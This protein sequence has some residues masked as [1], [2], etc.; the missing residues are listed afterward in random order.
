MKY[1]IFKEWLRPY[2]QTFREF[3]LESERNYKPIDT[4]LQDPCFKPLQLF[5]TPAEYWEGITLRDGSTLYGAT[6]LETVIFVEELA[7][8]DPSMYLSLP[9]PNLSGP[10]IENLGTKEQR[11]AY[12]GYF[13][14]HVAWSAFSLTEPGAG[15][16][17]TNLAMTAERQEDGSYLLNGTKRYIANAEFSEWFIVF[18]RSKKKDT[19]AA[20]KASP[21]A[22]ECFVFHANQDTPGLRLSHDRTLGQRA[23]RLG[24]V[25]LNNFRLGT[26]NVL[27]YDKKPLL[28]GLRGALGTFYHMRPATAAIAIGTSRA[29]IEYVEGLRGLSANEEIRL[30]RLKWELERGRLLTHWAAQE[31]DNGVFNSKYS[32]MAKHYMNQLVLKTTRECLQMVGVDGMTEH[33]HLEKWMRDAHMIEFMEGSTNIHKKEVATQLLVSGVKG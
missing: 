5:K 17:A 1:H 7:W 4:C 8:G 18:V 6:A 9:G 33:P 15:S 24:I 23:A 26:E 16:D 22:I 28:R 20:A 30:S 10:L 31:C 29:A 27:G 13:L 3:A 21:L 32:S 19:P 14:E 25:E 12:F 11:D 2:A